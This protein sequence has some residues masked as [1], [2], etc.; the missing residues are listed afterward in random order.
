MC[1][2]PRWLGA[3]AALALGCAAE[4]PTVAAHLLQRGLFVWDNGPSASAQGRADLAA[5]M[6]ANGLNAAYLQAQTLVHDNPDALH[7]A[8]S[9]LAKAGIESELLIGNHAW[10]RTAN[11]AQ[12]LAVVDALVGFAADSGPPLP[13]AVHLNAEPH[14]LPEWQTDPNGTANAALDLLDQIAAKLQGSSLRLHYDI[15]NWYDDVAVTRNGQTRPL[16]QWVIDRC[17]GV[18]VMDYRDTAADQLALVQGELD[19]ARAA[20][21]KIV[22]ASETSCG[23]APEITFC[24]EGKTALAAA[25][26]QVGQ[27]LGGD[28]AFGGVAVHHW[29]AFVALKP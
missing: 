18:L 22:V 3:L 8:I 14:A 11:H 10:A 2:S 12:A 4:P 19:Y 21:K 26:A 9:A 20:G 1:G 17:D 6:Q 24:E 5:L 7:A 29:Q 28:A 15:P 23:V 13:L 16:L 25:Q 27:A